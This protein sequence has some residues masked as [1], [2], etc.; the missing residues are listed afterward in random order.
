MKPGPVLLGF[1]FNAI[2]YPYK[3][4]HSP[5]EQL[6]WQH[7]QLIVCNKPLKARTDFSIRYRDHGLCPAQ[8]SQSQEEGKLPHR[9]TVESLGVWRWILALQLARHVT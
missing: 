2:K 6:P 9:V 4:K 1:I 8:Q 3:R 7:E 5:N